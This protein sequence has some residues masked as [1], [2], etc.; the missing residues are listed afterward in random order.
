MGRVVAI[1]QRLLQFAKM[2]GLR[3]RSYSCLIKSGPRQLVINNTQSVT[4]CSSNDDDYDDDDEVENDDV[5]MQITW[6]FF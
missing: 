3:I 2:T 1:L 5:D 6:P 4:R